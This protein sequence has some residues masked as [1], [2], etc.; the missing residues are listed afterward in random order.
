MK[1]ISQDP[2]EELQRDEPVL[3]SQHGSTTQRVF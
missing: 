2:D 1:L 3:Q